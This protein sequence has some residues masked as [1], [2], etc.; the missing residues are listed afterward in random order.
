MGL[1]NNQRDDIEKLYQ[2]MFHPM[3]VYAQNALNGQALAEEAVQDTFRIAC[4]KAE[5]LLSSPNPKGWLLNTLKYVIRN[6]IRSR[7]NLNRL[8]IASLD[9]DENISHEKEYIDDLKIDLLFSDLADDEDYKLI[10]KIA[11]DKC[12]ILEVAEE[13]GISLEACHKRVQR[14]KKRLK[15][16][17]Q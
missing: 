15:K 16:R 3:L 13:L 7:A 2:E 4:A 17:I 6:S 1:S 8:V 14:A 10:K 12:T 5:N 9:F 11:L